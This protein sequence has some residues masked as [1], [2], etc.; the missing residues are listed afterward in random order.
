MFLSFEVAQNAFEMV[1]KF[2]SLSRQEMKESDDIY[3]STV[4]KCA[5]L[6]RQEMNESEEKYKSTV[7]KLLA[8]T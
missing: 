4:L 2:A 1:I 3:N 6:S 5:S 8:N 7:L